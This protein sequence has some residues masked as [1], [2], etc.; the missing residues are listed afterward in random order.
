MSAGGPDRGLRRQAPQRPG[1]HSDAEG[2]LLGDD[3]A[4]GQDRAVRGDLPVRLRFR[5]VVVVVVVD[6]VGVVLLLLT[7]SV[8]AASPVPKVVET[9]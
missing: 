4:P 1:G 7:A 5:A 8:P 3:D 6:A 9:G 2:V